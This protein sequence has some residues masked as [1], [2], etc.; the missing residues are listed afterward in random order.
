[1]E[2][3]QLSQLVER[4]VAVVRGTRTRIL[5]NDRADIAWATGAH[6]VHLRGDSVDAGRVRRIAP[7]GFLIGRSIHSAGEG[8]RV[9]SAEALDVLLFGTVFETPSKPGVDVAGLAGLT[10]ACR[11]TAI[12]VLAIGGMQPARLPRVSAAG[13]A[14]FAAIGLFADPPIGQLARAVRAASAAFDTH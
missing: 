7:A 14:G 13:A 1:M 11:E 12:P 3:G 2:G 5:V 8:A 9:A 6:G 4:A 10:A